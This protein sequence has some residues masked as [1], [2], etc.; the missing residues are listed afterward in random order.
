MDDK[1][2]L[3][4]IGQF[5][6]ES[7]GFAS[8]ELQSQRSYAIDRYLGQPF[9]DEVEGR[10]Q[11]VSTDLRDTIE[12]ILPQA[13]RV[14]LGGD[15]V[16]KFTPTGPEDEDQARLET[17]YINWIILERNDSFNVFSTWFR[18]AL[19][20]K[21]GYVKAYWQ[22]RTDIK[23]ETYQGLTEDEYSILTDDK[24]VQ[25]V[26]EST[27]PDPYLQQQPMPAAQAMSMG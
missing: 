22:E 4:V 14:F 16:V 1:T 18:D 7:Y 11:V 8:G 5:E 9:G 17:Q 26:E 19:M 24:S 6:Q 21:V 13:L 15:D 20:S 27:Y 2:L 25:I 10:S 23:L 12:W 3:G